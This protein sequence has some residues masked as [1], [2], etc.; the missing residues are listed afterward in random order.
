MGVGKSKFWEDFVY[1]PGGDEYVKGTSKVARLHRVPLG[2]R[3]VGFFDDEVERLLDE[4]RREREPRR[5]RGA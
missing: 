3:A 2:E 1:H 5:T 4:L